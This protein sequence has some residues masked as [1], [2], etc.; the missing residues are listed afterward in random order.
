MVLKP[1]DLKDISRVSSK[2]LVKMF[3]DSDLEAAEID[4]SATGRDIDNVY[5]ALTMYLKNHPG[6]GVQIK[7]ISGKMFLIKRGGGISQE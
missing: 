3:L 7:A 5:T 4:A 6:L 1:V 2:E